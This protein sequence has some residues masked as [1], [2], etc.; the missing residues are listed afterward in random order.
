MKRTVCALTAGLVLA[1]CL[2]ACSNRTPQDDN[3]TRM[4]TAQ[5]GRGYGRYYADKDG[6]VADGHDSNIGQGIQDATDNMMEDARRMTDDFTGA[7][8]DRTQK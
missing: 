6:D 3:S 5:A 8:N 4:R 1:G 2:T 7:V